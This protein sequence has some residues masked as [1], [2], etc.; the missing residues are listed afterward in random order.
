MIIEEEDLVVVELQQ[1]GVGVI[2]VQKSA[3]GGEADQDLV[4]DLGCFRGGLN[5][6]PLC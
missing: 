3:L 4:D 5:Q 1:T 6:F 2:I